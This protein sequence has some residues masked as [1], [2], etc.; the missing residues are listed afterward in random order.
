MYKP[1]LPYHITARWLIPSVEKVNGVNKFSYSD[2]E[3][4]GC[5]MKSYGGREETVNDVYRVVEQWNVETYFNPNITE[6]YRIRLS[7]GSEWKVL[8]KPENVEMRNQF[9]LFKI[10]RVD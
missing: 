1:N 9:M 6:K 8:A 3:L 7:D 5:H 4:F 10:E 2:G